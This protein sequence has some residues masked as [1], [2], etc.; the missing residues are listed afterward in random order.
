MITSESPNSFTVKCHDRNGYDSMFT[1]RAD[2]SQE[3]MD[4]VTKLLAW[5]PTAGFT[6]TA[7][8]SPQSTN[9]AQDAAPICNLHNRPMKPSKFGGH[10]CPAKLADGSYCQE[11][12]P[13]PT[14]QPMPPAPAALPM[15]EAKAVRFANGTP[16]PPPAM[17]DS[18]PPPPD[19]YYNEG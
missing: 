19:S 17:F 6:P 15:S 5:L 9:G 11:K 3:F 7:R 4:R 18:T 16:P 8:R 14:P 1:V 13:A 12:Q 10:F 2:S